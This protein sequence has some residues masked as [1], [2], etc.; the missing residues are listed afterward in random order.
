MNDI[1]NRL[2]ISPLP[3]ALILS[4]K[5]LTLDAQKMGCYGSGHPRSCPHVRPRICPRP[6]AAVP[7]GAV[8]RVGGNI[9]GRPSGM[10]AGRWV[11]PSGYLINVNTLSGSWASL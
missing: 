8:R 10:G 5:P 1:V 9:G 3:E 4:I 7:L 6:R 2:T 11:S